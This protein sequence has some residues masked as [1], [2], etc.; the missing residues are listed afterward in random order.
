MHT[1]IAAPT[2][3]DRMFHSILKLLN[4]PAVLVGSAKPRQRWR[5]P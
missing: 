4:V 2:I 3:N 5:T 1:G